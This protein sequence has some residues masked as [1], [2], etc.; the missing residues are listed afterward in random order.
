MI[1]GQIGPIA[2]YKDTYVV[3]RLPKTRSGKILRAVIRKIADD[4]PYAVPATIDDPGSL[5][6]IEDA[7]RQAKS[8]S[9]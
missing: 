4:Q 5:A 2:C 6:D 8:S 1:R 7:L 9:K 3:A